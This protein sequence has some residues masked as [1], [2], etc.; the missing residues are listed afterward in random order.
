MGVFGK[1]KQMMGIG[2]V[3]LEIDVSPEIAKGAGTLTGKLLVSAKSGQSVQKIDI[4]LIEEFSTGRGQ[5]RTTRE[6]ELGK[7][8]IAQPF[9]IGAGES[10]S[11]DFNLPFRVMKS[12]SETLKEKGGALG[13]LGKAASFA[14]NEKSEFKVKAAASV[15]GTV[16]GPSA[17]RPIRLA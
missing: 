16:L 10:K 12:N 5:E 4:T 13:M 14:G 9:E 6:F 7:T 3:K 15:K 2:G 11:L 17:A 8:T 1:L